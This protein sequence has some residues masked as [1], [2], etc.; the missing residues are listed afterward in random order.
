MQTLCGQAGWVWPGS[1]EPGAKGLPQP[2]HA[3]HRRLQEL[4]QTTNEVSALVSP[5]IAYKQD[6]SQ[7]RTRLHGPKSVHIRGLH[8]KVILLYNQ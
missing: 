2:Y 3:A 5:P 1:G 6:T 8:C 4:Q 7:F